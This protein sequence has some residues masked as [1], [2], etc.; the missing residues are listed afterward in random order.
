MAGAAIAPP[1]SQAAPQGQ[2]EKFDTVAVTTMSSGHFIHDV[3]P[4]FPGP[5]AAVP[6]RET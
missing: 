4:A 5:A 3:Y 1:V 6:D 2:S